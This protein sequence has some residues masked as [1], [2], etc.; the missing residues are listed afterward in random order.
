MPNWARIL[1]TE[2]RQGAESWARE[3]RLQH[4]HSLGGHPTVMFAADPDGTRHGNFH[5]LSWLAIRDNP[6]WARRLNK[7]HSRRK[8]LPLEKRADAKELDSSNSSDALLMNCFCF[9]GAASSLFTGLALECEPTPHCFGY[10]AGVSLSGGRPDDTEVDMLMGS[11]LVEAKLTEVDFTSRPRPHVLRYR[12]L[13]SVFNVD[14]L[15]GDPSHFDNYQLI[16][17]VLAAAQHRMSFLLLIDGRRPDLLEA[18]R[19]VHKAIR[20]DVGQTCTVRT[21]QELTMAAPPDL[22]RFLEK[23]YGLGSTS[24]TFREAGR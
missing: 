13:S 6:A 7:P 15:P 18:W 23:K 1:R 4:Y 21:W 19:S 2:L 12:D 14:A 16:R 5:P 8:T 9:P 3:Q 20:E 11:Y 17:N 22:Q 10:L 24:R